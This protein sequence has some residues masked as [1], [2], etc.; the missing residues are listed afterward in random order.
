MDIHANIDYP[1]HVKCPLLHYGN[2]LCQVLCQ[3]LQFKG[4]STLLQSRGTSYYLSARKEFE[5]LRN[6]LETSLVEW[7]L[8]FCCFFRSQKHS[9]ETSLVEWKLFFCR[10]GARRFCSLET[11]LV[12]WKHTSITS[13]ILD[14]GTLGNFL[15]GMETNATL[16][17]DEQLDALETSL[18]EWKRQFDHRDGDAQRPLETSLVEWKRVLLHKHNPLPAALGN[19]LSGM[20]TCD[21]SRCPIRN[22]TLETSLVEWKRKVRALRAALE[23]TLETSLVEWKPCSMRR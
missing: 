7:K 4:K 18:V 9:L 21:S 1:L 15:S 11:S 10:R 8:F 5:K 14:I 20:E 17:P 6:A 22:G 23:R 13:A 3:L 12:E 16:R 2:S 19:F